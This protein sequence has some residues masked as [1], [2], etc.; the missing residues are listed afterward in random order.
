MIFCSTLQ[1][2]YSPAVR[3]RIGMKEGTGVISS[4]R[5]VAVKSSGPVKSIGPRLNPIEHTN[6]RKS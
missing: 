1:K 3:A 2:R 6:P 5:S 4:P